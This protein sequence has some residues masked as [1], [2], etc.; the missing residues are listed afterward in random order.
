MISLDKDLQ[1]SKLS[2]NEFGDLTIRVLQY[3][4]NIIS[5]F[6]EKRDYII[7]ASEI[8]GTT[9]YVRP[10]NKKLFLLEESDFS[11]NFNQL[12]ET[13]SRIKSKLPISVEEKI[14]ID[15][16]L[17]TIQQSIGAGLDLLVKPN[18]ARKLVGNRFEELIKIVFSE[19]WNSK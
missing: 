8:A 4:P 3:L 15:K 16:T 13:F 5:S 2:L 1:E 17:Y 10:I 7:Y 11:E 6:K 19:I 9:T 12:K 14:T 18:S